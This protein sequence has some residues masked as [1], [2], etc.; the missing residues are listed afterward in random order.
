MLVL[1]VCRN[2]HWE[3]F[4]CVTNPFHIFKLLRV[5]YS[6]HYNSLLCVVLSIVD[7]FQTYLCQNWGTLDICSWS[8]SGAPAA[9]SPPRSWRQHATGT[10]SRWAE[11]GPGL[12]RAGQQSKAKSAKDVWDLKTVCCHTAPLQSPA[13]SSPTRETQHGLVPGDQRRLFNYHPGAADSRLVLQTIHRFH[14]QFSQSR[15]RPLLGP[16]PGWKRLSHL[17]HY[18]KRELT[19]R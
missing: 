8:C 2:N 3:L 7:A 14:N 15:R 19:P 13:V 11:A 5:L 6:G 17:R 16:S 10:S 9:W 12:A 1:S 4:V 18:A